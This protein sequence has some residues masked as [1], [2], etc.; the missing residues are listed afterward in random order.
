MRVLLA[1][2]YIFYI[3]FVLHPSLSL[4]KGQER[5]SFEGNSRKQR[6]GKAQGVSTV[7]LGISLLV[8]YPAQTKDDRPNED[9]SGKY[10]PD[11]GHTGE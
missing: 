7:S 6:R 9:G 3:R 2:A 8:E 5:Q 10:P 4:E 11:G 1:G